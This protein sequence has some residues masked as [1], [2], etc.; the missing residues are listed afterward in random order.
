MRTILIIAILALSVSASVAQTPIPS[1]YL[2][3]YRGHLEVHRV[4]RAQADAIC[5]F[6]PWVIGLGCSFPRK[7]SCLMIIWDGA[8]QETYFHERAHCNG[9]SAAHEQ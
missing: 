6:S 7:G 2:G 5:R 8:P 1:R 9:W 3:A 4:S